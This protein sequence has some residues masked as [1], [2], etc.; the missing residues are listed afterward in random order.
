MNAWSDYT[1][2][3]ELKFAMQRMELQARRIGGRGSIVVLAFEAQEVVGVGDGA[4]FPRPRWHRRVRWTGYACKLVEGPVVGR[5]CAAATCGPSHVA[6]T[7]ISRERRLEHK[8]VSSGGQQHVLSTVR[9]GAIGVV[10]ARKEGPG[11]IGKGGGK[12]VGA[13]ARLIGGGGAQDP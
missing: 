7:R 12:G 2:F 6:P 8:I 13:V 5:V 9:I 11:R 10:H 1:E 4:A 3:I